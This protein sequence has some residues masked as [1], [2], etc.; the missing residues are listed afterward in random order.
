MLIN[1]SLPS[2]GTNADVQDYNGPITTILGVL[3]GQLDDY[4]ISNLSGSKIVSGTLPI[5]S[6]DS[7]AKKGWI[8]GGLPNVSSVTYNGNGSYDITF[9]SSVASILPVHAKLRTTRGTPTSTQ[10][11]DIE[12]D[13]SQYALKSSPT[14]YSVTDDITIECR[15]KL[16]SYNGGII[17]G[18][19]DASVNNGFLLYINTTGQVELVA[20]N[21]GNGNYSLTRSVQS[22]PLNKWVHIAATLD[23]STFTTTAS[24]IYIDGISVPNLVARAGTNPTSFVNT[25]DLAIG[26][27]GSSATSYFDGKLSDIRMWSIVRNVTQIRSNMNQQLVGNETGLIGYYKLNGDFN[28][29]QTNSTANNMSPQNSLLATNADSPSSTD[30]N[31]T[32]NGVNDFAVVMKVSGAVATVQVPSG[33]S[34]PTSGSV[35]SVDYS[36]DSSPFG[37]PK[38]TQRWSVELVSNLLQIQSSPV[39]NT[40]YNFLRMTIPVGFW[41]EIGYDMTLASDRA[42]AGTCDIGS[43][44][45]TSSSSPTNSLFT[46]R[47]VVSNTTSLQS[48]LSSKDRL[49][50]PTATDFYALG[51]VTTSGLSTLYVDSSSAP[52]RVWAI[53]VGI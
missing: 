20:F 9:A 36:T 13:S 53:P 5:T 33:C 39:A 43:T 44:L 15:I 24:Q 45:S 41:S 11:A 47:M 46:S 1:V 30:S 17:F 50:I 52:S 42:G 22:I 38:D 14:G 40:W 23:M 34:I 28:D 32:P 29:Y 35:S 48:R 2:D 8:T 10:C 3:N 18:R 26:R 7:N 21:G 19:C 6:F 49:F 4:N 12:A 16:E 37:F 31:G 51:R 27:A 25:G